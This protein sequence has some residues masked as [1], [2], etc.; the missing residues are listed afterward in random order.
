MIFSLSVTFASMFVTTDGVVSVVGSLDDSVV[1]EWLLTS[2]AEVAILTVSS[3]LLVFSFGFDSLSEV[4]FGGER[5][6]AG[7]DRLALNQD[8]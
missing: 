5:L 6:P 8:G 2:S 4:F 7:F 3:V 1:A